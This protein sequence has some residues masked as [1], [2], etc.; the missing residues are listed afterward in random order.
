ME[1][2]TVGAAE[3]VKGQVLTLYV[4]NTQNPPN[5]H[6]LQLYIKESFSLS[7]QMALFHSEEREY[8]D[9]ASEVSVEAF[10]RFLLRKGLADRPRSDVVKFGQMGRPSARVVEEYKYAINP[11][12]FILGNLREALLFHSK[13]IVNHQGYR[14]V[15]MSSDVETDELVVEITHRDQSVGVINMC[16]AFDRGI[17][18]EFDADDQEQIRKTIDEM[19]SGVAPVPGLSVSRVFLNIIQP[20]ETKEPV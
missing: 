4:E 14:V 10:Y 3:V 13:A 19:V 8:R 20:V 2:K 18:V 11:D 1:F 6:Y 5:H 16:V 15:I 7:D 12:A 17:G 9:V